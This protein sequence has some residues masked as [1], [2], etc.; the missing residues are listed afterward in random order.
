MKKLL[1]TIVAIL[2]VSP[3]F[4]DTEILS[5]FETY[6]LHNNSK[7]NDNNFGLGVEHNG[8]IVGYYDNS[9]RKDSFYVG[10]EWFHDF[11][12][13]VAIGVEAALITGYDNKTLAKFEGNTKHPISPTFAP[14]IKLTEGK[15]SAAIVVAPPISGQTNGNISVQFRYKVGK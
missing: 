11:S 4:A 2:M 3:A 13:H 12:E 14:E 10:H 6:H 15:F 8:W 7:L 9:Y 1:L 5:G